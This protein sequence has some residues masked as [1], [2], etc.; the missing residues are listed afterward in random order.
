MG[1]GRWGGRA[2]PH[3]RDVGQSYQGETLKGFAPPAKGGALERECDGE[4]LPSF[5]P[6]E[7]GSLNNETKGE[8]RE[9]SS[10]PPG[11]PKFTRSSFE[12]S[13]GGSKDPGATGS[14][15]PGEPGRGGKQ[16]NSKGSPGNMA[17]ARDEDMEYAAQDG[18]SGS[19]PHGAYRSNAEVDKAEAASKGPSWPKM[20]GKGP[21]R[22][23]VQPAKDAVGKKG[24]RR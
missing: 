19:G 13:K 6:K 15:Q 18:G 3:G 20:Q 5:K 11:D 17:S 22:T 9:T 16:F 4:S 24:W 1:D 10:K 7:G 2:S 23:P 12:P 14:A 8:K 21:V